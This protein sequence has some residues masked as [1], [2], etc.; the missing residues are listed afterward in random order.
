MEIVL[1]WPAHHIAS[2]GDVYAASTARIV[3]T[4]AMLRARDYDLEKIS[5]KLRM[6]PRHVRRVNR[7]GLDEIAAKLRLRGEP[8]F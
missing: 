3:Q 8:V 1:V 5:R 6:G 2:A 4:V 7:E